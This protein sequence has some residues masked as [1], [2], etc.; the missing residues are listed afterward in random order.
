MP[1]R[2]LVFR[3]IRAAVPFDQA[4]DFLD[5][6]YKRSG[7]GQL[8]ASCPVCL[9]DDERIF[10]ATRKPELWVWHCFKCQEGGDVI[11]LVAR[12]RQLTTKQAAQLLVDTF[13]L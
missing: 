4:L 5:V 9:H 13:G 11:E 7:N 10:V 3:D 2:K 6:K 1:K 8:R 12:K